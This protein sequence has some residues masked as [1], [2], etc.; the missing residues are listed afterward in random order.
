[1]EPAPPSGKA[2]AAAAYATFGGDRKLLR[3]HHV[4]GQARVDVLRCANAPCEG[5]ASYSTLNLHQSPN[6]VTDEDIRVEIAG[7]ADDELEGFEN[8][9][10][11]AG[12][13][14]TLNG[15]QA[16]PGSLM[17]G[18]VRDFVPDTSVPHLLLVSP[19]NLDDLSRVPVETIGNVHWLLAFPISE[20]ERSY[21]LENS[22]DA[23]ED[24]FSERNTE[25][26]DLHRASEV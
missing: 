19:Y 6:M 23:L 21:M 16:K 18:I 17:D 15:W 1:M 26:F 9:L 25:Y 7:V 10:A 22:F 24:L 13:A 11:E 3:V 20:G 5:W 4:D 14:L 8:V 2:V 12:F